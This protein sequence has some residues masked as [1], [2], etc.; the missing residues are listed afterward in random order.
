[1]GVSGMVFGIL[2]IGT[3]HGD[4]GVPN[5]WKLGQQ[6]VVKLHSNVP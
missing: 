3:R 5:F 6:H 2:H 1:M 4:A